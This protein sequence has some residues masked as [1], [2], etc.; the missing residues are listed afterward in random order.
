MVAAAVAH[1][2]DLHGPAVTV[3]AACA[4]SLVAVDDAMRRLRAG[5]IDAALAGG[6][7]VSL[8]PEHHIAFSRLGAISAAG[9]CLPFDARG[10][11]FV[12]GEGGGV[13]LL[14]RLTDAERDGNRVYAVL[15]G[16]AVNADGRTEGVMT[17]SA[18]GQAAVLRDA[19]RAAGL[20]PATLGYLEAHGTA[21][22][23]GDATEAQ[24]IAAALGD[25]AGA[26]AVGS[27][28][29]NVGHTMSAAGVAGL[30]RAALAV[31]TAV[32]PPMAGYEQ[33][34]PDL[35]AALTVPTAVRPWG[36][37][38]RIA[39]VSSFGFGGTNAHVV[40]RSAPA[41]DHDD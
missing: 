18:E 12:E 9:R 11:G 27:T 23:V 37:T 26:V 24:G 29:A 31:H 33:P 38:D 2:F 39:A 4:S 41:A 28:K 14:K 5:E 7:Y 22:A 6:V 8:S 30:I 20:D 10:D 32:V 3:D 35:P 19:W 34:R 16:S 17:P 40:L 1:Q 25:R 36:A 15:A 13:V 21:T